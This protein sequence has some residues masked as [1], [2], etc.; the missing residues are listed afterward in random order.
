MK[1][2]L[3]PFLVSVAYAAQM[4]V[5][6]DTSC[7]QSFTTGISNLFPGDDPAAAMLGLALQACYD[8]ADSIPCKCDSNSD[9]S[10]KLARELPCAFTVQFLLLIRSNSTK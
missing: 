7:V 2:S 10:L 4:E 5:N 1:S 3:L 9:L 8:Y 6:Q